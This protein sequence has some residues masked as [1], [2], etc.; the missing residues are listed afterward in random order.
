MF[1]FL[2]MVFRLFKHFRSAVDRKEET[3]LHMLREWIVL[4]FASSFRGILPYG[5][6]MQ[7]IF[8]AAIL[9]FPKNTVGVVY[10]PMASILE[11]SFDSIH[12]YTEAYVVVANT[13][14]LRLAASGVTV[15]WGKSGLIDVKEL[16]NK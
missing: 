12:A 14:L 16:D 6:E 3:H 8:L 13:W 10:E 11:K 1:G 2:F 9:F 15:L 5:T 4:G 7:V